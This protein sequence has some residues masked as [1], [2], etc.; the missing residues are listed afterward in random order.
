[1]EVFLSRRRGASPARGSLTSGI[2]PNVAKAGGCGILITYKAQLAL[3]GRWKPGHRLCESS[4]FL[5]I[6]A[7]AG[8]QGPFIEV[9]SRFRGNDGLKEA[10][11]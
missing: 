10:I 6:P 7:K 1:M 9:D 11:C 8:I 3:R 2:F 5:V 4:S